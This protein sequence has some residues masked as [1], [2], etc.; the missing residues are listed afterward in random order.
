MMNH[1]IGVLNDAQFHFRQ[2]AAEVEAAAARAAAPTMIGI[3]VVLKAQ[4]GNGVFTIEKV[5]EGGPADK[6]QKFLV[7]DFVVEVEGNLTMGEDFDLVLSWIRGELGTFVTIVVA[8]VSDL[9]LMDR[10]ATDENPFGD[11]ADFISIELKRDIVK[12]IDIY[13]TMGIPLQPGGAGPANAAAPSP[14]STQT[15]PPLPSKRGSMVA[16]TV[17]GGAAAA[18]PAKAF[19]FQGM[20]GKSKGTGLMGMIGYH[21]RYFTMDAIHLTW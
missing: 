4:P 7:G 21:D 2:Q 9:E 5:I 15:P 20:L 10:T 17:F 1:W 19:V 12:K 3:G 6:S 14:T 13:G 11:G 18:T 16:E 8:R